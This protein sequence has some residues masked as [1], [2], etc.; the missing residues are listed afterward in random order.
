[1]ETNLQE[2]FE[3]LYWEAHDLDDTNPEKKKLIEKAIV[4][5]QRS[6]DLDAEFQ[7]KQLMVECLYFSDQTLEA[8]SYFPWLITQI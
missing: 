3:N 6:K 4:L 1:M 8:Y 7:A 5:A 2:E